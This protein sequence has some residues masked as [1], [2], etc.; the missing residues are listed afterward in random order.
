MKT[1]WFS[2]QRTL[3]GSGVAPPRGESRRETRVC[4]VPGITVPTRQGCLWAKNPDNTGTLRPNQ[5]PQG[6]HRWPESTS[7]WPCWAQRTTGAS[8]KAKRTADV[9]LFYLH[10]RSFLSMVT[11]GGNQRTRLTQWLFL[12]KS[13]SVTTVVPHPHVHL[14][15]RR[16]PGGSR[17]IVHTHIVFDTFRM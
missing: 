16:L 6:V 9:H 13:V 4:G 17:F 7:Y 11:R 8:I 5:A 12:R 15:R 3:R 2:C 1:R 10:E 14:G